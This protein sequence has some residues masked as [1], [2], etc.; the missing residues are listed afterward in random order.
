MRALLSLEQ[1]LKIVTMTGRIRSSTILIMFKIFLFI[2]MITEIFLKFVNINNHNIWIKI[3]KLET[4]VMSF[5]YQNSYSLMTI[6]YGD[7][8]TSKQFISLNYLQS[9]L[10]IL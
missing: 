7:I 3:N 6:Q 2:Y 9:E 5:S 1:L 8:I 10:F 4:V